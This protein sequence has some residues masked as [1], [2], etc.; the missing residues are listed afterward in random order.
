MIGE[1]AHERLIG[2][3]Q[4]GVTAASGVGDASRE[5]AEAIGACGYDARNQIVLQFE[6]CF[7]IERAIV[8]FGPEMRAVR[9]VDELHRDA[10]FRPCL[11]QIPLHH[12]TCSDSLLRA[13]VLRDRAGRLHPE[14]REA[15]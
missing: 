10:Q 8:R 15:R 9:C 13:A 7:G 5:H 12:V 14:I 1:A 6:R 2:A 4:I 3:E 11:A